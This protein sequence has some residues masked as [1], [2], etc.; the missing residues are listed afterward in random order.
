[1]ARKAYPSDVSDEEWAFTVGYLTLMTEDAP[2]REYALREV[3][4]G[5]RWLIRAGAPWRMMPNDLPPWAV[6]YQQ[7]Q[8]WL[9]A[10]VFESMAHD[11]RALL[12]LADGRKSQPT[13]AIMD[14]RTLQ[15]TPESGA[16]AGYDGA[17]RRKGSK[18]HMAVDTLGHLLTLHVTPAN[19]QD[20]DQVGQLAQQIQAITEESVELVFVDQGYTGDEPAEV[21]LAHGIRLEVVKLPEAKK[22]FVL[23]PRRWVVER[24]FGWAARFRRLARDYERLP[25]TLAGLHYLAFVI[26]MLHRVVTLVS[27]SS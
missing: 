12:R 15:S 19:Q 10:G 3:F 21:A 20:R 14:S 27:Y 25:D 13:A 5:L 17:K 7:T 23:L 24:S 9:K 8:R 16:R 2:Q 6:V 4:N 26:L 11:L 18:V 22:G 1:M